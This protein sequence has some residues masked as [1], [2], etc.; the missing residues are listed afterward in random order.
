MARIRLIEIQEKLPRK[1]NVCAYA[2]VSADKDSMLHSLFNQVSHFSALIQ[3]EPKW[4]YVGIYSDYAKTGTKSTRGDFEQMFK[5]A[6]DGKIDLILVKAITRFARNTELTLK[7]IRR[8]KEIG[9]DIYFEQENIHTISA[10]GEMLITLLAS[11]A[12]EQSRTTSMNTLWRVKKNFQEGVPYGGGRCYG[13]HVNGKEF[14]VNPEE[15]ETVR[16]IY[17]MYIDGE[18]FCKIAKFLNKNGVKPCTGLT[19]AKSSIRGILSNV[20]YTG[21]LLLQKTYRQDYIS[22]KHKLNHGEKDMFFVEGNH[23]PIISREMFEKVQVIRAEKDYPDTGCKPVHIFASLIECGICGKNYKY[24]KTSY[25]PKYE[26]STYNDL[27][28]EACPSKA[29][30]E[31]ILVEEMTKLLNLKEFDEMKMRAKVE[32]I[33]AFNGNVLEV[34]LKDGT[35]KTVVWKDRPRSASWTPEMR[36][37]ARQK[38]YER[39]GGKKNG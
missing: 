23:E 17:N 21:D 22:K 12:Q 5:D 30:P 36:E 31:S 34:H 10:E 26:C 33:V 19:W 20:T 38:N 15:A 35:V 18:G 1:L 4:N 28:K 7:W 9:V 37:M 2:R 6:E 11:S 8:M 25:N 29:I 27:G 32:R 24:K 14:I 16:L 39:M 3:N 13:Y